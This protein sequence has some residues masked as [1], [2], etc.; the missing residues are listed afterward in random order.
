MLSICEMA[1]F[2]Y[3]KFIDQGPISR[4]KTHNK[5]PA[6]TAAWEK[7]KSEERGNNFFVVAALFIA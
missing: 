1:H 7:G 4:L 2:T 6:F 3:N 5:H